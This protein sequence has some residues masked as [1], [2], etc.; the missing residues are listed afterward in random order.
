MRETIKLG[1]VMFG[2]MA[3]GYFARSRMPYITRI[4]KVAKLHVVEVSREMLV[5]DSSQSQ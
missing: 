5:G 2:L 4:L 3:S 1:F